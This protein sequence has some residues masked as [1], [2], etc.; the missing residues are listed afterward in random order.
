MKIR[1]KTRTGSTYEICDTPKMTWQRV[2]KGKDSPIRAE[3]GDL[4]QWPTIRVGRG[5]VLQDGTVRK[6][7]DVHIVY[8]SDVT[9][10]EVVEDA[11]N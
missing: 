8:T 5:A 6:G 9:H 11:T 4:V 10:V 1:F 2:E 7:F 3:Q